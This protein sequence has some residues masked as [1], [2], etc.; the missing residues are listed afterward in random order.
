[1]PARSSTGPDIRNLNLSP[2]DL[3]K[4]EGFAQDLGVGT[5]DKY[6]YYVILWCKNNLKSNGDYFIAKKRQIF[7]RETQEQKTRG[8]VGTLHKKILAEV[9][10]LESSG[11]DVNRP[12]DTQA[13]TTQAI[14]S[15]RRNRTISSALLPPKITIT[16]STDEVEKGES[17]TVTWKSENAI[18]VSSSIGFGRRL[19][20][21]ELNGTLSFTAKRVGSKTFSI[22]V[23]S[24]TGRPA[25]AKA[26]ILIVAARA[27]AQQQAPPRPA[28]APP[29]Q[30]TQPQ[31]PPAQ[32]QTPPAQQQATPAQVQTPTATPNLAANRTRAV[33]TRRLTTVQIL[34]DINNSLIRILKLIEAQN[35]FFEK[36]T[37]VRFREAENERRQKREGVLGA[38][39]VGRK[40]I[41]SRALAPIKS[42]FE[43]VIKFFALIFLGRAFTEFV[44]W[45]SD[46]SNEAKVK[47]I[48]RFL[49][50]FWPLIGGAA[51]F[52]LTPLG[53]MVVKLIKILGFFAKFLIANPFVAIG[54]ATGAAAGSG[55]IMEQNRLEKIA[56]KQGQSK[57]VRGKGTL[58]QEI[59]KA[60]NPGQLG[61]SSISP[62][63]LVSGG[64][65]TENTGT[66]V[67]GAG[68]DTQLTALTPGE[69]VL[70]KGARER[71]ISSVG[72]DPLSFNIGPNA[73][74]PKTINSKLMAMSTGGIV[75]KK[76]A[77]KISQP[78]KLSAADYN[79]LLAISAV[80]DFHS[81]QGRADVA[82]SIYNRLYA[83]KNYKVNFN[84]T[85]R[86]L[87]V[88]NIITAEGQYEPVEK[89]RKL[90]LSINDRQSAAKAVATY[91]KIPFEQALKT[92]DDTDKILKNPEAQKKAREFV[93]GRSYF[94]GTSQKQNMK[95]GDVTRE[96]NSNFFSHWF[97]ENTPYHKERGNIA[98]PLPMNV[99]PEEKPKIKAEPQR[100][101]YDPRNLIDKF[102]SNPKQHSLQ[103]I[104]K[105]EN[106]MPPVNTSQNQS[107]IINLPA[108][109]RGSQNSMDTASTVV[110]SFSTISPMASST[111]SALAEIYGIS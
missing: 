75:G 51:L 23:R 16:L 88:K 73:N 41:M 43:K 98:A 69:A 49:R 71:M 1:M 110:P 94:L 82:Q 81:L 17:Y 72:I 7:D 100:P 53:G 31:T 64:I 56:E 80:E 50:D 35:K 66:K 92:I 57:P 32:Q 52:F 101:W 108:I 91:K 78:P 38:L 14:S 96:P 3:A 25:S 111:R 4:A 89:N 39:K 106:I 28:Q 9:V 62:L 27:A 107:Q 86:D 13:A 8:R 44:K 77:K 5:N 102:I 87:N 12:T 59:G 34:T 84:T 65:V 99:L 90:W 76:T 54:T 46:P 33:R 15:T 103:P 11:V 18:V 2:A 37:Q 70:Q 58:W 20:D 21:T 26:K 104:P 61:S 36:L 40:Y 63:G 29:T 24:S 105:A 22:T 30:P 67:K 74:R 83:A 95:S 97:T 60:F 93:R 42:L 109:S 10:L 79:T 45:F 48:T 68:T 55:F 47:T 6:Y 19:N 85:G